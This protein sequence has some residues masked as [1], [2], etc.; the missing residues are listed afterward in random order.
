[1]S[2]CGVQQSTVKYRNA[3]PADLNA[4]VQLHRAAFPGFFLTSLGPWFLWLLY[5][6]FSNEEGGICI[7]AE[8]VSGLLGF[9]AGTA[10]PRTFFRAVLWRRGWVFALAAIPGLLRHPRLWFRKCVGALFYRGEHPESMTGAGLLSS[11]AVAPQSAGKGVGQKLVDAF[12]DELRRRGVR[13][14]YLT[15]DEVNNERANGFYRKCGFH[16]AGTFERPGNRRMNRW[17]RELG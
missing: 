1:M 7:V 6:E 10:V 3:K 8:D 16:L 15:T 9:V 14:L 5:R 17:A 12:C 13:S 4:L 2:T 11:L